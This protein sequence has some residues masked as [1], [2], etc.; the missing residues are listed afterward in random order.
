MMIQR[1]ETSART[2]L[3]LALAAVVLGSTA[4]PT[5]AQDAGPR[6]IELRG[7]ETLGLGTSPLK[8]ARAKV[9]QDLLALY[10]EYQEHLKQ[11]SKLGASAPAF[12]SSNTLAPSAGGAVVIDAAAS[13]DPETLA[14]DLRALG[15]EN[16]AVFGRLVSARLPIPAIQALKNV[17]SLQFARPAYATT[18]VGDVTSQGDTA[19]RADL[20]RAAFGVDGTGVM[21]GTLS[22]SYDCHGGA[23]AGVASGDLPVGILVLEE[24]P[25]ADGLTDEGRG[26]MELIRDVAPGASQAF[27]T[28]EGGQ[29]N[30]AQ[31]IVDLRQR[32]REGHQRRFHLFRRTLLPGRHRRP[33]GQHRQR[34]GGGLFQLGRQ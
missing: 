33:G 28:S 19:M 4:P 13:G 17:S 5:S 25:C 18:H 7:A 32:R 34:D 27:H 14:A 22:E 26:M 12:K 15:A 30:F 21:V 6:V 10:A 11:T 31:G 20:G 23:A 1:R 3:K 29:A 24:G 9:G 8:A 16:V 2:T